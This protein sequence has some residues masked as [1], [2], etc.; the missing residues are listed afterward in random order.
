MNLENKK[1]LLEENENKDFIEEKFYFWYDKLPIELKE[2][3]SEYK[4]IINY[5][6]EHKLSS[7]WIYKEILKSFQKTKFSYLILIWLWPWLRE[8]REFF[9]D[10]SFMKI[11]PKCFVVGF[12][13]GTFMEI[14]K[15]NLSFKLPSWLK[16]LKDYKLYYN[17][18]NTFKSPKSLTN[19]KIKKK[20]ILKLM[21][22]YSINFTLPFIIVFILPKVS[23]NFKIF[24]TNY[25][26]NY[27]LFLPSCMYFIHF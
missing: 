1:N 5:A 24:S 14:E 20:Y 3:I 19:I 2:F 13:I 27:K 11:S 7:W 12:T 10:V 25:Q 6:E 18:E 21:Y 16:K 15:N 22:N 17:I 26:N 8:W 9:F 4:Y 23:S